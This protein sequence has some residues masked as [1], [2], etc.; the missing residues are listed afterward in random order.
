MMPGPP[1]VQMYRRSRS[2]NAALWGGHDVAKP[3]CQIVV[4]RIA[5]VA[6]CLFQRAGIATCAGFI[7]QALRGFGR[8]EACAAKHHHRVVDALLLLVHVGL[9]QFQLNADA[10]GFTARHEFGVSKCH[11]VSIGAQRHTGI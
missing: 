4:G 9:E 8:T 2:G 5:H 11:A 7:Q 1:P 3:V 10:A 6:L